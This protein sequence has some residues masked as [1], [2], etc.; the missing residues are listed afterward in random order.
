VNKEK[1]DNTAGQLPKVV[2]TLEEMIKVEEM[3]TGLQPHRQKSP[4]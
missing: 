3:K 1:S 4:A 2:V